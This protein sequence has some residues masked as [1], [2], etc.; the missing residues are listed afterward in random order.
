MPIHSRSFVIATLT[1]F[2]ALAP[3]LAEG[4]AKYEIST[5]VEELLE[6]SIA[7]LLR[8]PLLSAT[9]KQAESYFDSPGIVSYITA[10]DISQMGANNLQD[11]LRRLPNV[12]TPSLYLFRNNVTSVR[13]QQA[14]TD[15]RVLVLLNGRPMRE[16]FNGGVNSP[17]Y[18]GFP[19]N[20]INWIE[21]IRGPGSVLHGSGAFS[22]VVNIV[23]KRAT[24]KP[25]AKATLSYGSFGTKILDTSGSTTVSDVALSGGLKVFDMDGWRYKARD[26]AGVYDTTDYEQKAWAG[27]ARADYQNFSLE[28]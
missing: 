3:A 23:T 26:S 4:P 9:A 11:L 27:T 16:T 17:I 22:S 21:V 19:L 2:L 25:T 14:I 15:T 28:V 18:D 20:L 8:V 10:E 1:S 24:D 6:L 12:E 5:P 7:E 13:G